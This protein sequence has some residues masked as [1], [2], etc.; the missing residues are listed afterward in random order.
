[1]EER[2]R[3]QGVGQCSRQNMVA[4]ALGVLVLLSHLMLQNIS[5]DKQGECTAKDVN[6][7]MFT[8]ERLFVQ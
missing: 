3:G 6:L 5:L 1:M 8:W 4:Y 2:A 7:P